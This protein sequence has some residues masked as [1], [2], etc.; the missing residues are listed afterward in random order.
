MGIFFA[1]VTF[2]MGSVWGVVWWRLVAVAQL[3]WGWQ[4]PLAVLFVGTFALQ[5]ARFIFKDFFHYRFRTQ[6]FIYVCLS[7]W[8]HLFFGAMAK[9]LVVAFLALTGATPLS[10]ETWR[11]AS[12]IAVA[13]V[14]VAN[15]WGFFT[16][17]RGPVIRRVRVHMPHWPE[18]AGT[19]RLAQISD[20]HVSPLIRRPYVQRVVELVNSLDADAVAVTGDLGDG[21]VR[22][23]GDDL[24][25]LRGMHSRLG[26]YYVSGNHEH[27]WD[28][29]AWMAAVRELGFHV[30]VNEGRFLPLALAAGKGEARIWFGGVPD[31]S[32]S[33]DSDPARARCPEAGVPSVLLAHQP[34][35]VFGAAAAG[36]DLMVCGHTHN[37]QFFPI[38]FLVGFFNPYNRGLNR[39]RDTHTQVYVNVGTGYWGPPQ[40]LGVRAEITLLELVGDRRKRG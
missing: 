11:K 2:V 10:V 37:G 9:D 30:L 13:A 6:L 17:R 5:P 14:L 26:T 27:Y 8:V 3:P 23:L 25:P 28:V 36:F 39:H 34:K 22:D 21:D 29:G 24:A 20:L 15:A 4:V 33:R 32:A 1:L 40:R 38:N 35:S 19:F 18:G 7:L 31:I 16:A 12:V